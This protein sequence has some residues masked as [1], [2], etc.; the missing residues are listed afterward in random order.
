MDIRLYD[1]PIV[2]QGIAEFNASTAP[3]SVTSA[4]L[5]LVYEPSANIP[6][7]DFQFFIYRGNGAI[8]IDDYNKGVFAATELWSDGNPTDGWD[9]PLDVGVVNSILASGADWIGV[10]VRVDDPETF[11]KL[12]GTSTLDLV[13]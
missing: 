5:H 13:W 9:V 7:Q 10:N 12:G 6:P 3:N 2:T 1:G 11:I 4:T 8:G